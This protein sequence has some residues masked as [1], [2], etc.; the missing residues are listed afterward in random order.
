MPT[1]HP[2][3]PA[4]RRVLRQACQALR[5]HLDATPALW[6]GVHYTDRTRVRRGEAGLATVVKIAEELGLGVEIRL[7]PRG[8]GR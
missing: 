3:T 6:T 1:V 2:S 7:T 4:A 5:L 8:T